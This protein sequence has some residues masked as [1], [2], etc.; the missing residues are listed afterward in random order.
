MDIRTQAIAAG[1]ST[2]LLSAP[3]HIRSE[4]LDAVTHD[5]ATAE[6]TADTSLRS[7]QLKRPKPYKKIYA[8]K[9]AR[10][11]RGDKQFND[12]RELLDIVH[13]QLDQDTLGVFTEKSADELAAA[14]DFDFTT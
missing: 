6:G 7:A 8:K 14:I 4:A 10:D 9:R 13:N 12:M 5:A 3:P 1:Q 11:Y 2:A